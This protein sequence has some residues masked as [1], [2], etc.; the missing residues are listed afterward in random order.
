LPFVKARN[1]H[2]RTTDDHFCL[3]IVE[4]ENTV[5]KDDIQGILK[6][7]GTVEIMER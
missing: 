2:P 5:S 1:P 4:E 7:T 3:E 6:K